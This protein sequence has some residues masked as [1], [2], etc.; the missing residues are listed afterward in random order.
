[1]DLLLL[2]VTV[3]W[4]SLCMGCMCVSGLENGVHVSW[5]CVCLG[6]VGC[7]CVCLPSKT[8]RKLLLANRSMGPVSYSGRLMV[9]STSAVEG[10]R[11]TRFGSWLPGLRNSGPSAVALHKASWLL[12]SSG[13][14]QIT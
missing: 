6:Y 5:L 7:M 4:S 8:F 12:Y 14:V 13:W 9:N 2:R 3:P 1:M 10:I 11:G